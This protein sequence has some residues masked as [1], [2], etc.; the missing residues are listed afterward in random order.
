M[1]REDLDRRARLKM[2]EADYRHAQRL[3]LTLAEYNQAYHNRDPRIWG[4]TGTRESTRVTRQLG[5]VLSVNGRP[6]PAQSPTVSPA[7][8][9]ARS[10]RTSSMPIR[11]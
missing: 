2:L 11:W 3:G 8:K 7:S 10:Q 9:P 4:R 5:E 1:T 6:L